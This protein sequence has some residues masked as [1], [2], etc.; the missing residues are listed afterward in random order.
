[1]D[2]ALGWIIKGASVVI[3]APATVIVAGG[4][5]AE[6][7]GGLRWLVQAAAVLLVEGVFLYS[8][9][10]LEH[11]RQAETA[12]KV[13]HALTAIGL[14]FGLWALAW[15]HG[16]GL[17]G[18]VFRLALGA[19][20][21][22]TV[23]D[24]GVYD[25]LRANRKADRNIRN[26]WNVK[27]LERRLERDTARLELTLQAAFQQAVIK[28]EHALHMETV[29]DVARRNITKPAPKPVPR[30]ELPVDKRKVEQ[31]EQGRA[32]RPKRNT[33]RK[34]SKLDKALDVLR[35]DPHVSLRNLGDEL[36]VSHTTAGRYI[37]KLE[38]QGRIRNAN[39]SG[40]EVLV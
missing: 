20:L 31:P 25:M 3:T 34:R 24:A 1:M 10:M 30:M 15:V 12:Y 17:A 5:F 40:Y 19:A 14:Y 21:F 4:L 9:I 23:Y 26:T 36:G 7:P 6:V 35:A 32:E 33:P 18:I 39:G 11:D 28:A 16:E 37:A 22:G 29:E 27:R 38:E 13:R 2:K 8:W